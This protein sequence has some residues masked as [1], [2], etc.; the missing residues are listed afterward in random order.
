MVDYDFLLSSN[1]LCEYYSRNPIVMKFLFNLAISAI[2]S[3]RDV[4][5]PKYPNITN[6]IKNFNYDTIDKYFIDVKSDIHLKF[7]PNFYKFLVFTLS[8]NPIDI[9]KFKINEIDV[10]IFKINYHPKKEKEFNQKIIDNG[11]KSFRMFHG[12]KM[13]NWYSIIYSGLKNL[14][15]TKNMING[16]AHGSGVYFSNSIDFALGYSD[17]FLAVAE[18]IGNETDFKKTSH[19][20]VV[21]DDSLILIKYLVLFK[22]NKLDKIER[23]IVT[24][25]LLCD[26]TINED[27]IKKKT[28]LN[29]KRITK[30]IN[31]MMKSNV[32]SESNIELLI[33]DDISNFNIKF[34]DF[35]HEDNIYKNLEK[36]DQNYII[37]NIKI[38]NDYPFNPPFIRIISPHFYTDEFSFVKN[39]GAICLDHL[40]PSKWTPSLKIENLLIQIRCYLSNETVEL[41]KDI[42]SCEK[43]SEESFYQLIYKYNWMN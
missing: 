22:H 26:H 12:S 5:Y 36:I 20:Y 10:D 34:Y 24:S 38:P 43:S 30:E 21:N 28:Q 37:A 8:T 6:N 16:C 29:N 14:S 32:L 41:K 17:K 9:S 33:D 13:E 31:K 39:N 4:Y 40:V 15:N 35:R 27:V 7:T 3:K 23:K 11:N 2:N 42:Y 1:Y 18:I 19:I 25:K